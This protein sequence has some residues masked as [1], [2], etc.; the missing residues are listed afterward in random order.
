MNKGQAIFSG[1]HRLTVIHINDFATI[2]RGYGKDNEA[3][4]LD[5]F[6]ISKLFAHSCQ[7]HVSHSNMYVL[8]GIY[9]SIDSAGS[10]QY[11]YPKGCE[12]QYLNSSANDLFRLGWDYYESFDPETFDFHDYIGK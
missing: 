3:V 9:W 11:Y 8:F 1:C 12:A 5:S 6:L 10:C 7:P 2:V 4:G